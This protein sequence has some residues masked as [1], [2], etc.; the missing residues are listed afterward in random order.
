MKR[1]RFARHDRQID[2]RFA[3]TTY[4]VML[5]IIQLLGRHAEDDRSD[6]LTR[7]WEV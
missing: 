1:S 4:T 3:L 6:A 5:F 2:R 7:E